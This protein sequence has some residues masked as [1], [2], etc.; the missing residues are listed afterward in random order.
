MVIGSD[1]MTDTQFQRKDVTHISYTSGAWG[2]F[3]FVVHVMKRIKN[4]HLV[5]PQQLFRATIPAM[6]ALFNAQPDDKFV[7]KKKRVYWYI[8]EVE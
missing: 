1:M 7:A 5:S 8:E 6:N 2:S 3:Y 4:T